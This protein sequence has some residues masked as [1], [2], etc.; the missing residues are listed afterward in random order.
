MKVRF[1]GVRGSIP[2]PG[3]STIRYGGNTP[4]VELRAGESILVFD[5][6]SGIRLLGEALMQEFG[7]RPLRVHLFISHTHWDHIQ[8]FPFFVPAYR[9]NTTLTIYGPPGRD[10][11][12]ERILKDQMEADY[13]P[14]ALGDL[15]PHIDM[16][17]MRQKISLG[18]L[19]VEPFYLNHPAMTLGYRVTA[20]SASVVYATDNEPY[21]Y[22]LVPPGGQRGQASDFGKS[23]DQKFV[24]FLAGT[25]LYIA[26]AQYTLEE[27][28]GGKIGWG[29]SP[30]D[31]IAE[32]AASGQ[33]KQLALFH[34][35]PAHDDAFVDR[36]VKITRKKLKTHGSKIPCYAAS[37]GMTVSIP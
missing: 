37:E 9:S 24:E 5:A 33:V 28:L 13:F 35:D 25:D 11:P 27:Y 22:T 10:K 12:L 4:C 21:A 23:Q 31:T 26:E 15:T 6:G 32:F 3:K 7:S 14:V 8:G 2:T 30:I 19:T 16:V 17:E 18:S 34:H 20:G 29:H 36:M 1:W